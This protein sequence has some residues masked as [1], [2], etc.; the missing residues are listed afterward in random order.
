MKISIINVM[1]FFL[2]F[3]TNVS[4]AQTVTTLTKPFSASGGLSI[5]KSGV[6]YV[7]DF[8]D[9]LGKADGKNVYRL[10]HDGEVSIFASGFLG[11]SGNEFDSKGN[12]YQSNIASNRISKI[13]QD[14]TVSLFT[15]DKIAN[16]VGVTVDRKDNV[17]N[18]N[19][20]KL[21]AIIKTTPAGFSTIFASDSLLSCPNGLTIDNDGNLYAANFNNGKVIKIT[22]AGKVSVLATLPGNNNGH[23]IFG[24]GRLYVV[25]RGANQIYEVS[26]TG[27]VKLIAGTGEKGNSDGDALRSTWYIPNGI[28]ISSSGTELYIS[29][30]VFGTG[31]QLNPTVVRKITGF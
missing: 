30:K 13:T 12:L 25:A 14:G 27:V 23:L 5:D 11:A 7:A 29:D 9:I 20:K 26:L 18:T 6:I 2:L 16:P 15:A 24:N 21:G 17:Y 4:V 22:R 10:A 28:G 1:S 3:M 19:C 8:G 31:T